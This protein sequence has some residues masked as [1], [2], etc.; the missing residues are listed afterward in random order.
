MKKFL[1]FADSKAFY[2]CPDAEVLFD[3][4]NGFLLFGK[5][6]GLVNCYAK[7]L[8]TAKNVV[9]LIPKETKLISARG[10][11]LKNLLLEKGLSISSNCFQ[12]EYH[13]DDVVIPKSEYAV[14]PI[15]TS[16]LDKISPFYHNDKEYLRHLLNKGVFLGAFD[17]Q[18][19]LGMIGEHSRGTIGL[20]FV[21]QNY[22]RKGIARLL[23]ATKIKS[24]ISQ[25]RTPVLHVI[26]GNTASF[27]LQKNMGYDL[28][29]D[30]V[31]W[32]K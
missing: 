30:R 8:K 11:D 4:E 22:R 5:S 31:Y 10:E 20:L 14:R 26:D 9:S 24:L 19:L 16:F 27:N 17:G 1:S 25:G 28:L 29:E 2:L 3:D 13:L 23:M 32:L 15:G 21:K 7:D 6:D 12:F 18:E